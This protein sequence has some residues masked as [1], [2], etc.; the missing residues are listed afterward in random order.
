MENIYTVIEDCVLNNDK[1]YLESILESN[2]TI[3]LNNGKLY[4]FNPPL[5]KAAEKGYYE[6]CNILINYGADVNYTKDNQTYPL[7][8]ACESNDINIAKLL[9]EHG[10]DIN[11]NE[12]VCYPA[13]STACRKGH[14]E[15]VK[16]LIECGADVNRIVIGSGFTPLDIAI[17]WG[18]TNL[19]KILKEHGAITNI[20]RDYEWSQEVGG[21]ISAHID[22]YLG[23]VVPVKFNIMPNNVFNRI[24]YVNKDNNILLY[25]IGNYQFMKH[26]TE[27]IMVLPVGWNPYSKS[28]YS[29]LPYKIMQYLSQNIMNGHEFHDGDFISLDMLN[30]ENI[31]ILDKYAGFHIVDYNYTNVNYEET[32][33]TV[34]LLTVIP[35]IRK[36]QKN[37]TLSITDLGKLKNKKW[38][39]LEWK[40]IPTL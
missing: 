23:R 20:Q 39:T 15:I 12:I 9:I 18:Q 33:D 27:F 2:K 13:I 10:A 30:C 17:M 16:Y 32:T 3:D 8:G 6:I 21:G 19:I 35:Q 24:S 34:T 29:M 28:E 31:A 38:K 11:G 7:K 40:F 36:K 1:V 14:F 22:Y 25:S 4:V 26:P 5:C 37:Y